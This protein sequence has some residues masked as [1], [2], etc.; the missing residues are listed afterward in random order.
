MER[1]CFS[2][3]LARAKT[4]RAP[5]PLSCATRD[6]ICAMV[7]FRILSEVRRPRDLREGGYHPRCDR[8]SAELAENIRDSAAPWRE[9]VRK[10]IKT[11]GLQ[12]CDKKERAYEVS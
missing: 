2:S 11:I 8:K 4:E 1:P 5:S 6:A 3:S 12:G 9:R 7:E 10:L